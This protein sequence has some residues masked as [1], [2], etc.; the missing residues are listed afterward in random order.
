MKCIVLLYKKGGIRIMPVRSMPAAPQLIPGECPCVA[1]HDVA[2][3]S[4]LLRHLNLDDTSSVRRSREYF[5]KYRKVI[6][7]IVHVCMYVIW[8]A[9]PNSLVEFDGCR[10]STQGAL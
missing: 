10:Y 3:L 6:S 8:I 2:I 1:L 7:R 4:D 5:Y 9:N